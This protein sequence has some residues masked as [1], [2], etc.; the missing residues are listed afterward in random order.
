MCGF[1]L[2]EVE[3]VP[4]YPYICTKCGY[5]FEK[6]QSFSSKPETVCPKCHGAL[7]RTLTAPAFNFKGSGWY[8]N[9]YGGKSST[10]AKPQPPCSASCGAAC[11]A[12]AAAAASG[13]TH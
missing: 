10:P 7:E 4:L 8:V 11:P 3:K 5:H 2:E 6:I 9:D 12:A 13:V 1:S